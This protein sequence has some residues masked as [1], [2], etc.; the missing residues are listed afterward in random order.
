MKE[1]FIL[2]T[3]RVSIKSTADGLRYVALP[4]DLPPKMK[5]VLAQTGLFCIPQLPPQKAA[6]LISSDSAVFE[7]WMSDCAGLRPGQFRFLLGR[8]LPPSDRPNTICFDKEMAVFL[9]IRDEAVLQLD[10]KNCLRL[11]PLEITGTE[12]ALLAY[13]AL[14]RRH[15]EAFTQSEKLPLLTPGSQALR[16][17][18][19]QNPGRAG[20]VYDNDPFWKLIADVTI[21]HGC[22]T[23]YPR[24]FLPGGVVILPRTRSGQIALIEVFRHGIRSLSWE[25]PRGSALEREDVMRAA[26]RELQEELNVKPLNLEKLG[27]VCS[28]TSII[29]GKTCVF[30]AEIPDGAHIHPG[31]EQ[32]SDLRFF[33]E[34]KLEKYV[35][36]GKI[37][38]AFTLS[39]WSLY[40]IRKKRKEKEHE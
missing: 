39:A 11:L 20:L 33:T 24:L 3:C 19:S 6:L 25:F 18:A 22:P 8:Q 1:E 26:A 27:E 4:E 13:E 5:Q 37:F 31:Y 28:D 32:H 30:L 15:P 16:R 36:S 23:S 21:M 34:K 35:S 14:A 38:D 9:K 7:K 10:D 29:A 12:A 40:L 17:Y 2:E